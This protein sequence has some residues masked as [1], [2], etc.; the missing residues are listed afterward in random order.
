MTEL[1]RFD[2][3]LNRFLLWLTIVFVVVIGILFIVVQIGGK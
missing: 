1:S 3:W 2:R